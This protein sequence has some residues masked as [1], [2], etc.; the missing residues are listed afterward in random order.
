M[1][2]RALRKQLLVA[3]CLIASMHVVGLNES[4]AGIVQLFRVDGSSDRSAWETAV[5]HSFTLETFDDTALVPGLSV[6]GTNFSITGGHFEDAVDGA[7][8]TTFA[9]DPHVFAVGAFFDLNPLTAGT[10]LD[11]HFE[12]AGGGSEVVTVR[13]VSDSQGF[14]GFVGVIAD[15]PIERMVIFE[16]DQTNLGT[17]EFYFGDDLVFSTSPAAVP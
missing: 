16:G 3:M 7:I 9:F 10:G 5:N 14:V 6:S 8:T 4:S 13:S 2:L 12:F 11:L 15:M 17:Y 1:F